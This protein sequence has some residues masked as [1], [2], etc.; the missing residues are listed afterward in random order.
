MSR[1]LIISREFFNE[2]VEVEAVDLMPNSALLCFDSRLGGG[3]Q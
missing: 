1:H 2:P 3:G